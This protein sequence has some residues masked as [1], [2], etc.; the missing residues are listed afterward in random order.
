MDDRINQGPCDVHALIGLYVKNLSSNQISSL[1]DRM[2]AALGV[3]SFY[4]CFSDHK[5]W[6]CLGHYTYSVL[7]CFFRGHPP[8]A[9]TVRT[10][11]PPRNSL[12][13]CWISP[14]TENI[15]SFGNSTLPTSLS[16]PTPRPMVGWGWDCP[17]RDVC[18]PPIWSLGGSSLM[19]PSCSR[20]E[21]LI[22]IMEKL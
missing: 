17:P 6:Q 5:L 20:Y 7:A 16:R 14:E 18:T 12:T 1:D 19:D 11:P 4:A 21:F 13:T 10:D 3:P 15:S 2:S 8:S 9:K 22:I